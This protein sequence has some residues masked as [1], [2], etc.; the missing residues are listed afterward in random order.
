MEV[1]VWGIVF[2]FYVNSILLTDF[3]IR[4]DS[5]MNAILPLNEFTP[6]VFYLRRMGGSKSGRDLKIPFFSKWSIGGIES[7]V[8]WIGKHI[9]H[10]QVFS[11]PSYWVNAEIFQ[12]K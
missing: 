2:D 12:R 8:F 4:V 7:E 10:L 6:S 3:I 9:S 1:S 11:K 5:P